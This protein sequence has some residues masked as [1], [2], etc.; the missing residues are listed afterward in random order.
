M[1]FHVYLDIVSLP[2]LSSVLREC[3]GLPLAFPLH[4]ASAIQFEDNS[5]RV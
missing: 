1:D 2:D 5:D 3:K 4:V